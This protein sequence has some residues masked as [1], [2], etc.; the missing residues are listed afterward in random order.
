MATSVGTT[1]TVVRPVADD[2]AGRVGD[3]R[4]VHVLLRDSAQSY[5]ALASGA[6]QGTV[7]ERGLRGGCLVGV[8][9]SLRMPALG[10]AF[11]VAL[12]VFLVFGG[13]SLADPAEVDNSSACPASSVCGTLCFFA[14][15]VHCTKCS[16]SAW[17]NPCFRSGFRR[18][19]H[20]TP[21]IRRCVQPAVDTGYRVLLR[22]ICLWTNGRNTFPGI[23]R[24]GKRPPFHQQ[25]TRATLLGILTILLWISTTTAV[26]VRYGIGKW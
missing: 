11:L 15:C 10:L 9:C 26:P 19:Q 17:C 24:L 23:R 22:A 2:G 16:D 3:P 21:A 4:G 1:S 13:E 14:D 25:I 5:R 7:P 6:V 12:G 8:R 20:A 18:K